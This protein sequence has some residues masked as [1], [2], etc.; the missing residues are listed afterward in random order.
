[1]SPLSVRLT[2]DESTGL[3]LKT[4]YSGAQGAIEET[5]TDLREVD[6]MKVPFKITVTQGGKK[7]AD[8]TVQDLKLNTGTTE[9]QLSKRQ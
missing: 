3:P 2:V 6:G 9:E 8:V 1:M 7:F 5:W 4:S